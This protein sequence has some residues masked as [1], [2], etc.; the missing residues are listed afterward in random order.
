MAEIRPGMRRIVSPEAEIAATTS[1]SWLNW[2]GH[3]A[4]PEMVLLVIHGEA[5]SDRT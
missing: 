3:A 4:Q 1:P 2:T 5:A